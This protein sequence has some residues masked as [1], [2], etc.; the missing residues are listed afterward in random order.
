M[1]AEGTLYLLEKTCNV[2]YLNIR[3]L[4][5]TLIRAFV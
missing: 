2:I 1:S 4:R 5:K 3:G